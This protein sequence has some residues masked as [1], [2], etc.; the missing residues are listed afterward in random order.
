[1]NSLSPL[2]KCNKAYVKEF[3]T[4]L[5]KRKNND[6]YKIKINIKKKLKEFERI[7]F[8]SAKIHQYLNG[9]YET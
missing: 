2:I 4:S 1:M 8:K 7:N 9:S 5:S 6:F 3:L